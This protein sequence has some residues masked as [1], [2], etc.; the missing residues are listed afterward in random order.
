MSGSSKSPRKPTRKFPSQGG[1]LSL[2]GR[3]KRIE[4]AL[5]NFINASGQA[6]GQTQQQTQAHGTIIGE[7]IILRSLLMEKGFITTEELQIHEKKIQQAQQDRAKQ[8]S[9]GGGVR[10]EEAGTDD[11]GGGDGR[12]EVPATEDPRVDHGDSCYAD[13]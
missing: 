8:D 12:P 9:E 2:R 6:I 10:S 4:D 13:D 1:R 5:N 3:I 11:G 7:Y